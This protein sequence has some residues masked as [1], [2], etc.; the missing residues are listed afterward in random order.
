MMNFTVAHVLAPAIMEI[1]LVH[2]KVSS[3]NTLIIYDSK[4]GN[5]GK[6]VQAMTLALKNYGVV[7]AV[8]VE[9]ADVFTLINAH[10]VDL[11]IVG[12]PT[13]KHKI[14]PGMMKLLD[15]IPSQA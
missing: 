5:T 9:D 3:M 2:V 8:A 11:L 13:Q 15:T 4:F 14:S 7:E 1:I 6:V 12:C 10:K